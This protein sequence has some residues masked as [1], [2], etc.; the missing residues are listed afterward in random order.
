MERKMDMVSTY[1]Q[2]NKYMKVSGKTDSCKDM[3]NYITKMDK[4]DMMVNEKKINYMEKEKYIII[5]LKYLI[6]HLIIMI[7]GI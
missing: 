2:E 4:L 1:F 6:Q 3:G 7:S 5:L